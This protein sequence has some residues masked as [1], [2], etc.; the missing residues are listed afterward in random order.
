MASAFSLGPSAAPG[1]CAA[2]ATTDV[3]RH[4]KPSSETKAS[5]DRRPRLRSAAKTATSVPTNPPLGSARVAPADGRKRSTPG[6]PTKAMGRPRAC[7]TKWPALL[8]EKTAHADAA[9]AVMLRRFMLTVVRLPVLWMLPLPSSAR[10]PPMVHVSFCQARPLA[11]IRLP[12]PGCGANSPKGRVDQVRPASVVA[13]NWKVDL[14]LTA[15][16]AWVS[17]SP[18]TPSIQTPVPS[19]IRRGGS[20]T[21]PGIADFLTPRRQRRRPREPAGGRVVETCRQKDA[22]ARFPRGMFPALAL[23]ANHRPRPDQTG[24]AEGEQGP[25]ESQAR[26]CSSNRGSDG[27]NTEQ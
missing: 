19:A 22:Y 6:M 26:W 10:M 1:S 11:K 4:A 27:L 5:T 2:A 16:R 17:D 14:E 18:C 7:L 20:K 8:T 21:I 15:P 23:Q 3:Y 9:A 13:T 24:R 12:R 25:I